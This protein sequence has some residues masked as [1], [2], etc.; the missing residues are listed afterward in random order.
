M[1]HA[2]KLSFYTPAQGFVAFNKYIGFTTDSGR[3]FTQKT[4]TA[5]NVDYSG[6][7]VNLTF[8][9]SISGVKTFDSNN[10]FVYGDYGFQPTILRSTDGGNTFKIV[11]WIAT[12]LATSTSTITDLVFPQNGNIGYAIYANNVIKTTDGGQTWAEDAVINDTNYTNLQFIDDTHGYA[13]GPNASV[14]SYTTDGSRWFTLAATGGTL[15]SAFFLNTTRGWACNTD[16]STYMTQDGGRSWSLQTI[17]SVSNRVLTKMQ[18]V[19][20]STGYAIA[21]G[22]EV[23][24]TSNSGKIWERLPRNTTY[25]YL[26][27]SLNDLQLMNNFT[28]AAGGHGYVALSTNNGGP[29]VP[30]PLFTTDTTGYFNTGIVKLVNY[31]RS[32]YSYNW[33][34]NGKSVS[35]SYNSSYVHNPNHFYDTISLIN[36]NGKYK[37]TLTQYGNHFY[38]VIV[39]SFT[40]ATAK[41]GD[42]V[43]ITGARLDY[44]I[45]VE[46]GGVPAASF[47]IVSPSTVTAVV[48]AGASGKVSVYSALNTASQAGFKFLPG[49]VISSFSPL[50]AQGGSTITLTGQYFTGATAVTFGGVPAA[51]FKVVS[52]TQLTAVLGKGSSG[53]IVVTSPGGTGSIAGFVMLP[54]IDSFT[55][56]SGGAGTSIRINGSGL[57]GPTAVTIGGVAVQSFVADAVGHITAVAGAGATGVIT[58]TTAG[59]N[60]SSTA[61]FT[62]YDQPVI[63]SFAPV[64]AKI[65]DVIT[66]KGQHFTGTTSVMFGGVAAA[67]FNVISD[68]QITAVLGK[69]SSGT[70]TVT[71][72]GGT[73]SITGFTQTPVIDSFT[74]SAGAGGTIISINGSGF[75]TV[76]ALTIGGVAAQSFVADSAGHITAVAGAGGTGVITI[77]TPSGNYSST[78][79][80]TYYYPPAVTSFAPLNG[81][82][83]ATITVNGGHFSAAAS[84][85]AV[86]FGGVPATVLSATPTALKVT[87]PAGATYGFITVQTRNLAGVSRLPFTVTFPNGGVLDAYS[88]PAATK[89]I[90]PNAGTSPIVADIDGDGKPDILTRNSTGING[91]SVQLNTGTPGNFS[92]TQQ[93]IDGMN[94]YAFALA[95]LDGDGLPELLTT[96]NTTNN[97]VIYHNISTPGHVAFGD[98]FSFTPTS[99]ST[100]SMAIA[101]A[102]LDGDGKPDIVVTNSNGLNEIDLYRNTS[103]PGKLSFD[104]AFPL[105][106]TAD[107]FTIAD[108]DGDGK[109]DLLATFGN[110]SNG[111]D[112]L[113]NTSTPGNFSFDRVP[114]VFPANPYPICA[115]DIDGDGKLDVIILDRQSNYIDVYRNLS[116]PGKVAFSTLAT[117]AVPAWP[118]NAMMADFDGDGKPDI[119]VNAYDG[120][121]PGNTVATIFKNIS[122]PGKLSLLAPVNYATGITV[123][124]LMAAADVD[125]D[126]KA[127]LLFSADGQ[128]LQA[129]INH[130][131]PSPMIYTLTPTNG[132]KGDTVHI[133]GVNL[134][135]AT[136]VSFGGVAASSFIVNADQ[137]ITATLGNGATGAVQV[138]NPY[139]TASG[140]NF[141]YGGIPSVISFTPATGIAGTQVTITGTNFDTEPAKNVVYFG[142][143]KATVTSA[144]ATQL[145]ATVPAGATY[146][147]ITVATHN[148]VAYSALPFTLAF[149]G[150]ATL[151]AQS[152]SK[153]FTMPGNVVT[154]GDI[155]GDGNLDLLFMSPANELIVARSQGLKDSVAF[156]ANKTIATGLNIRHIYLADIDA[157]GKPDIVCLTV[158]PN[159]I[160]VYRNTSIGSNISFDTG[161]PLPTGGAEYAYLTINDA[162]GDGLPDIVS[163]N[164]ARQSL[165]VYRNTTQAG[166]ISFAPPVYH[167]V[168]NASDEAVLT[169]LD[170]DGKTEMVSCGVQNVSLSITTNAST[171][172]NFNFG[173]TTVLSG[174]T[175]GLLQVADF[176]GDGKPDIAAAFDYYFQPTPT[177][178]RNTGTGKLAFSK[179]VISKD[180]AP[181]AVLAGDLNGDGKPEFIAVD[182]GF[183]RLAVMVNTSTPGT[184]SFNKDY[185]IANRDAQSGIGTTDA[186]S[187]VAA[188]DMDQDGKTDLIISTNGI[189]TIYRNIR[190]T[191]K[192]LPDTDLKVKFTSLSCRGTKDGSINLT[193]AVS[194]P[195]TAT[196]TDQNGNVI[197]TG[198]F[199]KTYSATSLDTGYYNICVT[200]ADISGFQQCLSGRL[201]EPQDLSAFSVVN[202]GKQTADLHLSGG[203]AY[204]IQVNDETYHTSQS[205]YTVPLQKGNN[206]L[207]ITTGKECQGVFM[208]RITIGNTMVIYPNPFVAGVQ[209]DVGDSQ[210]SAG[211]VEIVDALGRNV[212]KD[213]IT[214][215]YGKLNMDLSGLK[216]GFYVVKLTI[217][218][219]QTVYKL[220]KK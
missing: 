117:Y 167:Y 171:P 190:A 69:G 216:S 42:V 84:D 193:A 166:K 39:K 203:D 66:I 45:G 79:T 82:A 23:Y 9:F 2:V 168:A 161:V 110:N 208:Q 200:D 174:S 182:P 123:G 120:N 109:P 26:G 116:T 192:T 80:F 71:N 103:Q 154:T 199:T 162:D 94:A 169:D 178:F 104:T 144:S 149:N 184:I 121:T 13:F 102:D 27:Y 62:Y 93:N 202:N 54:V 41:Q 209:I 131:K 52:D 91:F 89:K 19:N 30:L 57:D 86:Y 49:P 58:V 68:T 145:V 8:G 21:A 164:F 25:H 87:V 98:T 160:I 179:V 124:D 24:K 186:Y 108:F 100:F 44:T 111:I 67:S 163:T 95:D 114:D 101:A 20:D 15:Q 173:S 5:G 3:T 215:D 73:G 88:F 136:A 77:T 22:F 96:D 74:P 147:P 14:I 213:N 76:T 183:Q 175:S 150:D 188:G 185:F 61:S 92:Y 55:P 189:I 31:S 204:T 137:S 133:S 105:G 217:D 32:G 33:F 85:N 146:Q 141:V 126:G 194:A 156:D 143:A 18:F 214:N 38:E 130:V 119:A 10:I 60:F 78:A 48:G 135:T 72:P 152:F 90:A 107:S 205:D 128:S 159:Q 170:G 219:K 180:F 177:F 106:G 115:G 1:D 6:N 212:Y 99:F 63:T 97:V 7:P 36:T 151:D 139:G 158:S 176:D 148:F 81:P 59:G 211:T 51:S 65:G 40:P 153:K 132:V 138:I 16:G 129:L 50:T 46:F 56:A 37:D 142:G 191:L 28:W 155:D 172:G 35:T 118:V 181:S 207:T 113:R 134:A 75:S 220:W 53:S 64:T 210:A 157:D 218:N 125:G 17:L 47:T 165:I 197:A 70:V 198:N 206:K 34:V 195:Y 196:V 11:F 140:P 4:I 83:G 187:Q 201:G 29:T 127:D 43:T 112:M 122:T 12:N